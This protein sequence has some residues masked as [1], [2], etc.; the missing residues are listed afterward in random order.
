MNTTLVRR[1]R[2]YWLCLLPIMA[3]VSLVWIQSARAHV[4]LDNPNGGEMLSGG[5]TFT[6]EWRPAVAMHDTLNFDLWYSTTADSGP[7]TAIAMNVPPGDLSIGSLHTY[8][9]TVPSITDSSAWVRVRQDNNVDQDYEDVSAGS[10]SISAALAGDFNSDG[11]VDAADYVV[12]RKTSG[13]QAQF[14][15]WRANFGESAGGGTGQNSLIG[16]V[17]EPKSVALLIAGL[18]AFQSLPLRRFPGTLLGE[19]K[20]QNLLPS[21]RAR[22]RQVLVR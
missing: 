7:W 21:V 2:S 9:W 10:F 11:K 1:R 18:L 6:I 15:L 5:S 4:E 17:P 16:A 14:N 13:T 12:W 20:L 19:N 22:A 3:V 8:A